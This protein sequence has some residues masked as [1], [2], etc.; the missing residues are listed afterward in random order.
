VLECVV[1]GTPAPKITWY[2]DKRVIRDRR[3]FKLKHVPE[4]G[5]TQ[6]AIFEIFKDD[7]GEIKC[8]AENKYGRVETI[9]KVNVI[10]NLDLIEMDWKDYVAPDFTKTLRNK[11]VN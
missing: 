10:E 6:L 11:V 5:L 2:H 3:N 9:A 4:I 7:E 8:V 1:V